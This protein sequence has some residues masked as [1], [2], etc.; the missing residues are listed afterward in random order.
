[1]SPVAAFFSNLIAATPILAH[2]GFFLALLGGIALIHIY[3]PFKKS[4]LAAA[5]LVVAFVAGHVLGVSDG[6]RF[7]K[8]RW[9]AAKNAVTATGENARAEAERE[10]PPITDADPGAAAGSRPGVPGGGV[11]C[12]DEWDRDCH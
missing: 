2:Y 11:Q 8:S 9:E 6:T 12:D 5:A 1:M 7:E 3:T 10:V 4:A